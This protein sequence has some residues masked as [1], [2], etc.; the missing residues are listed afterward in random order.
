MTALGWT[1]IA[2]AGLL[3]VYGLA[4]GL[5]N[6]ARIGDEALDHLDD[7]GPGFQQFDV[8]PRY[9]AAEIA[10]IEAELESQP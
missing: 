3:S 10:R 4:W 9:V 7:D 6:A 5:C 1:C 2:A 8:E